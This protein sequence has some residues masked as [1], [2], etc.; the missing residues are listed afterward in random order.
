M[1]IEERLWA[2]YR[3]TGLTVGRHPMAHRRAEMNALGV[4][5][6]VDLERVRDG[7]LVRIAG[8]VI[9]RLRPGTANGFVFL[10]MEDETGIMN[11]I[12]TP[13]TFDRFKLEVLGE[14]FLVN[15]TTTANQ[16]EPRVG[17]SAGG[18]FVVVWESEHDDAGDIRFARSPY[19]GDAGLTSAEL[20]PVFEAGP[21][22]SDLFAVRSD[23]APRVRSALE[24]ALLHSI[25]PRVHIAARALM[26]ADGFTVPTSEHRRMLDALVDTGSW[27]PSAPN[28]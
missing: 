8:S 10:S 23:L 18:T 6:A 21:I 27:Y 22:P 13:D 3:G 2:D 16:R 24:S 5:R 4:K 28:A 26:H 12:V 15:Q 14:P 11:A 25:P 19:A 7:R 9:V 1:D 17:M 20:R